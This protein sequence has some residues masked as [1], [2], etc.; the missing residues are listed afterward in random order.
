LQVGAP[1]LNDIVKFF[2]FGGDGVV[3]FFHRRNQHVLHTL[4]GGDVH[5]RGERIVR[6]LRHVHVVV[7]MNGL[8]CP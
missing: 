1:D 5:G 3:H 8:F 6:R 4:S 2:G 7:G